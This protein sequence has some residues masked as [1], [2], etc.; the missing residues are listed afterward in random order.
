VKNDF[1]KYQDTKSVA[2]LNISN[3]FAE[4]EIMTIIQFTKA[5]GEMPRNKL[6]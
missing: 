2:F 5:R 1:S 6:S 4:K 3:Q